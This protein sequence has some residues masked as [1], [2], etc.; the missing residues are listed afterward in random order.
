M[1]SEERIRKLIRGRDRRAYKTNIFHRNI[2][3]TART[4]F[5]VK[6]DDGSPFSLFAHTSKI[7]IQTAI[8]TS[9]LFSVNL[10]DTVCFADKLLC[11]YQGLKIY[12]NHTC[13]TSVS[14]CIDII[15][16]EIEYLELNDGEGLFVYRNLI[17]LVIN[18]DRQVL[19][20]I[21]TVH[22]LKKKI[23]TVFPEIVE[24]FDGSKIS[25]DLQCLIPLIAEWAI[26]DDLERQEKIE[27]STISELD[28][29]V[30]IVGPKIHLINEY[31]DSF[32]SEPLHHEAISIGSLAEL[33]SELM[34]D[35]DSGG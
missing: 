1:T 32:G 20:E 9:L 2:G 31:L 24:T 8:K 26:S 4:Y 25:T 28:E 23:E 27:R 5:R 19:P 15:K 22:E 11:S 30:H 3:E 18:N 14:N 12:T 33:V 34:V 16:N 29:L 13:D 10:P 35:K 7:E 21:L 6:F 17:S